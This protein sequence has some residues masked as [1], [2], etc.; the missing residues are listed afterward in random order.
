MKVYQFDPKGLNHVKVIPWRGTAGA[1]GDYAT[2]LNKPSINSVQLNGN[3][4]AHDLGL[5]T[6]SDISSAI[7]TKADQS[8]LSA[9]NSARESAD[10]AINARIDSIIALPDGS[11]TADAELTDIR[12]GADGTTYASAGDAVRNQIG[13]LSKI[14]PVLLKVTN[15]SYICESNGVN[16]DTIGSVNLTYARKYYLRICGDYDFGTSTQCSLELSRKA[17]SQAATMYLQQASLIT[18]KPSAGSF[19]ANAIYTAAATQS[20][21][22][23]IRFLNASGNAG[24]AKVSN[25]TFTVFD[26]TG[27][28]I[29]ETPTINRI[30]DE[31]K[32][33]VVIP[34]IDSFNY[35]VI[36][37]FGDS[38]TSGSGG[39]PYP[40][41]LQSLLGD[42]YKVNNYG[43]GGEYTLSI[44]AR[45][46]A[47][48]AIIDPVTVGTTSQLTELTAHSTF[49]HDWLNI[50]NGRGA[51]PVSIN[52]I[53]GNLSADA[54]YTKLLFT[55]LGYTTETQSID[56]PS[57][58]QTFAQSRTPYHTLILFMG[59]NGG[60]SGATAEQMLVQQY[61]S[62]VEYMKSNHYLFIGLTSGTA[63]SR[64]A[65][66][67][68]MK[69]A[70]G[71]HYINAREYLVN[72]GLSDNNLSPTQ[73]DTAAIEQGSVPP[74]LLAD[75]THLN[76]AGYAALA[77]AI[78]QRG[79]DFA[80]WN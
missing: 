14:C 22:F 17:T 80:F 54:N 57:V 11:T 47:M 21:D 61:M 34:P 73:D 3:K 53:K 44:L 52:G 7:S 67:L 66:E 71:G 72:Y 76:T 65:L 60:W 50:R 56:R 51:N 48:P 12:V 15:H 40:T 59:Q 62:A 28:T 63:S 33:Y 74:Q 31:S 10:T 23:G 20:Y 75:D 5:A 1:S 45:M 29:T 4:T 79:K 32:D 8:D 13:A 58:I 38:L 77:K 35:S 78:Y 46:G 2:L 26:V 70:F 41:A 27:T 25:V 24:Q 39:T 64:S 37:C 18:S 49:G 36:D 9:E 19:E 42:D 6:P 30:I 69:N 16:R 68:A 55:P 43:V